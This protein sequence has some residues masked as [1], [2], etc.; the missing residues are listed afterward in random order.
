M[1][2][3]PVLQNALEDAELLVREHAQWATEEISKRTDK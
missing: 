3:L 2:T 1:H